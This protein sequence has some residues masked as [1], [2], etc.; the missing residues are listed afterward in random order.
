MTYLPTYLPT[1]QPTYL[2]T[3]QPTYSNQSLDEYYLMSYLGSTTKLY[4]DSFLRLKI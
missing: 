1:D 3:D 4:K 2:P